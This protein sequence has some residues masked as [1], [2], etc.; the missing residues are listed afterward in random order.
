MKSILAIVVPWYNPDQIAT[1]RDAWQVEKDDQRIMFV[2]DKKRDGCSTTK[3]RGISAAINAGAEVV[4][5]LDDDCLPHNGMTLDAFI[6]AHIRALEPQ[7]V[8]SC[9]A[10]TSPPSRGTPYLNQ[11]IKM[12]V[13]ASLGFWSGVPDW[14]APAQL[15]RGKHATMDFHRRAIFGQYFP[16][17][18]MNF[19]FRRNQWPWCQLI[20]VDRFDDIWMGW[21]WER[22]AYAAGYCFNLNGPMVSHSR[23]SNVWKNLI[24]EAPNLERNDHLWH[25]IATSPLLEHAD[26]LDRHKLTI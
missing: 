7:L 15:V 3:N 18:G 2:E 23:Q 8:I 10:V 19:A 12:D 24:A 14:D 20:K 16:F 5:V 22:Y 21:L 6:E 4:I 25:D 11:H 1:F 26:M 9:V 17:C 13:A